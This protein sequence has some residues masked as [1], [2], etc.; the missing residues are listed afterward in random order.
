MEQAEKLTRHPG[1]A[2]T[3]PVA[4]ANYALKGVLP[5]EVRAVLAYATPARLQDGLVSAYVSDSTALADVIP[6]QQGTGKLKDYLFA[7]LNENQPVVHAYTTSTVTSLRGSGDA[8][9]PGA[10]EADTGR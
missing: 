9:P 7:T 4:S 8:C 10:P 2:F 1:R 6:G 3:L 5:V